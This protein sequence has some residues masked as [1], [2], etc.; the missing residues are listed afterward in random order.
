MELIPVEKWNLEEIE[1]RTRSL[2]KRICKPYP[3]PDVRVS[4]DEGSGIVEEKTAL[5]SCFRLA[6]RESDIQCVKG[7][8]IFKT[9]DNA[10][11]YIVATSK[12]YPQGEKENFSPNRIFGR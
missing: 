8:R 10:R 3:Y 1:R 9:Q 11:S 12:M 4:V 7:N 5:A 2:I 6:I